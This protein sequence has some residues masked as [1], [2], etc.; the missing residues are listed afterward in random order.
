MRKHNYTDIISSTEYN[1]QSIIILHESGNTGSEVLKISSL[2]LS[3]LNYYTENVRINGGNVAS[4]ISTIKKFMVKRQRL[5]IFWNNS[6]EDRDYFNSYNLL[7]NN[8][9]ID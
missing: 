9:R 8:L 5:I 1:Q 3:D 6:S 2:N 7:W 4:S